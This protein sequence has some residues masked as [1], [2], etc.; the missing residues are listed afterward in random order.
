[1]ICVIYAF[2]QAE[3]NLFAKKIWGTASFFFSK[4]GPAV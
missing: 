1:M 2:D 3:R 4:N